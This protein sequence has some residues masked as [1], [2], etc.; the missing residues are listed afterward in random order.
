MALVDRQRWAALRGAT[1]VPRREHASAARRAFGA[2]GDLTAIASDGGAIELSNPAIVS[3]AG[4]F[5]LLSPGRHTCDDATFGRG[6]GLD[7][8]CYLQ[9]IVTAGVVGAATGRPGG[10]VQVAEDGGS[11]VVGED[12]T[13]WFGP[14][15]GR[16][17]ESGGRYVGHNVVAGLAHTC[18]NATFG[19]NPPG[20]GSVSS[21]PWKC[22]AVPFKAPAPT[23]IPLTYEEQQAGQLAS[24]QAATAAV[25]AA[26]D[27]AAAELL[28]QEQRATEAAQQAQIAENAAAQQAAALSAAETYHQI[29][30]Q[31]SDQAAAYAAQLAQIA[32]ANAADQEAAEAA[33]EIAAEAEALRQATALAKA[34]VAKQAAA[35]QVAQ[36]AALA[37]FQK[38]REAEARLEAAEDAAAK[39]AELASGGGGE[40]GGILGFSQSEL[41]LYGGIGLV[42]LFLLG[43]KG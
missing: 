32:A 25:Q 11:F 34:D 27:L 39:Q 2:F 42:A 29:Q 33:A 23:S 40:G 1:F 21:V 26:K 7:W 4:N 18:N 14:D 31:A 8:T 20:H 36:A 41:L 22:Y 28:V 35:N 24:L 10:S 37:E 19:P 3:R 43:G 13:I 17:Y 38:Q 5:R 15:W 9:S 30:K 16:G 6:S 12:S